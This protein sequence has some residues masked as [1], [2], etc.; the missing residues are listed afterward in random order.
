MLKDAASDGY[1]KSQPRF[2][3]RDCDFYFYSVFSSTSSMLR[4]GT[5]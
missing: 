1:K 5:Q 3:H 2:Y 4:F